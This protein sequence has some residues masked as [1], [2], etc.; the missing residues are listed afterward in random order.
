[1]LSKSE[2]ATLAIDL[3]MSGPEVE[4]HIHVAEAM[5]RSPKQAIASI[6]LWARTQGRVDLAADDE[7]GE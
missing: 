6:K 5:G 1:M 7:G 4:A 2:I 3:D